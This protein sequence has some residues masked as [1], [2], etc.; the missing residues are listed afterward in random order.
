M[1]ASS[2]EKAVAAAKAD[3]RKN[4]AKTRAAAHKDVGEHAAASLERHGLAFLGDMD[5]ATVSGFFPYKSEIDLLGLL[6]RLKG[7]GWTTGLPIVLGA[8]QPLVFRAWAPGE[9]TEPGAWEIPIPQASAQSVEPDVMLVPLLAFDREGYRLGYGGGFYDRTIEM[10]R[11]SKPLTAVGVAF[12]AQEVEKVIR[13][14]HDQPLD[15]I[16]TEAGPI[17]TV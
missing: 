17:K 1:S 5:P 14:K 7:E 2:N 12:A 4:A 15:W 6:G 10:Y 9:P 11:A 3:A 16:L 8:G 13:G